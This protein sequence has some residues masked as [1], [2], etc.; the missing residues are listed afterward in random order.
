MDMPLS[1][2]FSHKARIDFLL[3]LL[4][5]CKHIMFYFNAVARIWRE[6]I[7]CVT[8]QINTLKP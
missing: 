4:Q 5:S 1:S 7:V 6:T 3:M 8:V 2:L